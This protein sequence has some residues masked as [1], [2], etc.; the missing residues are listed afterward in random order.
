MAS[1]KA[2]RFQEEGERR[3][4]AAYAQ[5]YG[6]HREGISREEVAQ[7]YTQWAKSNKYDMVIRAL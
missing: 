4:V 2:G 3:D 1:E 7:Y 5:N 6:A